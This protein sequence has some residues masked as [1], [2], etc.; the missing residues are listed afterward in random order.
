MTDNEVLLALSNMLEP[1][2]KDM[3]DMKNDITDIIKRFADRDGKTE[4]K[5][6]EQSCIYRNT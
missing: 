6:T 3:R 4:R 1:I 2:K 5:R